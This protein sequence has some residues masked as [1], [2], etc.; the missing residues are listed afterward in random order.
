[1]AD[2]RDERKER[3]ARAH[4]TEPHPAAVRR[5]ATQAA[6][7]R[8]KPA[9]AARQDCH[10]QGE[11]AAAVLLRRH[12]QPHPAHAGTG[13]TFALWHSIPPSADVRS[14]QS[15]PEPRRGRADAQPAKRP[16]VD[17]LM[18]VPQVK[19]HLRERKVQQQYALFPIDPVRSVDTSWL[20]RT[21]GYLAAS[22]VCRRQLLGPQEEGGPLAGA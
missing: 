18:Q 13:R 2:S 17:E 16:D 20:T 5:L 8:P 12:Q 7:Q 3:L 9:T 22:L 19:L 1:M 14:D 10:G 6:V 15:R 21:S 11:P 4:G